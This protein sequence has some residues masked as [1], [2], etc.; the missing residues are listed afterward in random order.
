MNGS[1]WSLEDG[2]KASS[3]DRLRDEVSSSLAQDAWAPIGPSPRTNAETLLSMAAGG[4]AGAL[5]GAGTG[6]ANDGI[7]KAIAEISR[8]PMSVLLTGL[9]GRPVWIP[10]P[11][12][13]ESSI[14]KFVPKGAAIGAVAGLAAYGAYK[15]YDYFQSDATK[16]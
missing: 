16:K 8:V 13:I 4:S 15:A 7:N 2:A 11:I 14:P 12:T 9:T 6:L 5:I 10:S 1:D 3:L